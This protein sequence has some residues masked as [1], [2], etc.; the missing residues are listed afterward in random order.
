MSLRRPT[1]AFSLFTF[2]V[3]PVCDVA[4]TSD[5]G[6]LVIYL[7]FISPLCGVA[8]TPDC[9]IVK[10]ICTL[11]RSHFRHSISAF[12]FLRPYCVFIFYL[13]A[14]IMDFVYFV[15]AVVVMKYFGAWLPLVILYPCSW[16]LRVHSNILTGLSLAIVLARFLA[17][18]DHCDDSP[19][20]YA[21][22]IAAS[23]R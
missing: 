14:S 16:C 7:F 9:G 4:Q 12:Y 10:F 19:G 3:S 6:I 2:I 11:S 18:R 1:V 17:W 5:G 22:V 20:T 15:T 13:L 8:Q 21:I 23:R